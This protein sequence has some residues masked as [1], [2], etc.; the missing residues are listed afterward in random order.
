M[1]ID[2]DQLEQN[3]MLTPFM[4]NIDI[5]QKRVSNI[6]SYANSVNELKLNIES[7]C[8][9]LNNKSSYLKQ[10]LQQNVFLKSV[11]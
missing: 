2:Y 7:V 1:Q 4:R 10:T 6:L 8:S 9:M 3:D 5:D 11:L